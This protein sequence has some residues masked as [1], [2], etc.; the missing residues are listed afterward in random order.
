MTTY[1]AGDTLDH[2]RIDAIVAHSGMSVLYSATDLN[3]DRQVAIKVLRP[4]AGVPASG[5][6]DSPE[7]AEIL[8]AH[9]RDR[10]RFLREIRVTAQLEQPGIPAV[11]DTGE[12]ELPGGGKELWLVMQLLR[13]STLQALLDRTD[14]SSPAVAPTVAWAAAIFISS[15]IVRARTSSAPRKIPGKQST[16]LIWFG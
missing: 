8:D 2:Y 11:Y 3:A 16:L 5:V 10:R 9:D 13:G 15:V 4:P 12:S 7:A 14:Y 6:P 1:E